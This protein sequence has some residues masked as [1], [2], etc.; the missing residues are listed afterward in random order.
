M[1]YALFLMNGVAKKHIVKP[2]ALGIMVWGSVVFFLALLIISSRYV[3]SCRCCG[4][5]CWSLWLLLGIIMTAPSGTYTDL[6]MPLPSPCWPPSRPSHAFESQVPLRRLREEVQHDQS[7]HDLV[8]RPL[9]I[10]RI[11]LACTGRHRL[12][13]RAQIIIHF[14]VPL[15]WSGKWIISSIHGL[16]HPFHTNGRTRDLCL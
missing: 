7:P 5:G 12:W 2:F 4:C 8:H 6:L 13:S 1:T 9:L 14:C 16:F 10:P 15:P 3:Q 11:R